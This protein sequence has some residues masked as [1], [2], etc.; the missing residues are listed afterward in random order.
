MNIFTHEDILH[1]NKFRGLL[2]LLTGYRIIY[3]V[4]IA[5]VGLAAL[6]R[7]STAYLL[8]YFVDEI[9]PGQNLTQGVLL[10]AFGFVGL[11]LI[12]GG[13][14]FLGGRLAAYTVC[15]ADGQ[16]L[17]V[18]DHGEPSI[19][20]MR[21]LG[22]KSATALTRIFAASMK[23]NRLTEQDAD[24]LLGNSGGDRSDGSGIA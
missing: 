5:A 24:E 4:A 17:F 16:L 13:F 23:L 20:A 3:L 15:S 12:Q 2:R 11:A 22:K 19:E 14:T 1:K 21:E 7:T 8:R 18:D 9:L 6:A 10:V